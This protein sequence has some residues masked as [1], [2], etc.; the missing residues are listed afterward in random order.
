[1]FIK[2]APSGFSYEVA[3]MD[4]DCAQNLRKMTDAVNAS[5]SVKRSRES[6]QSVNEYYATD[7][8]KVNLTS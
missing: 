3:V 8:E 2:P 5:S 7:Q 6:A 4:E 1:M